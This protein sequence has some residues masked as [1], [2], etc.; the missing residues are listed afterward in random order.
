MSAHKSLP[1]GD[2]VELAV[3]RY[4]RPL[5][6]FEMIRLEICQSTESQENVDN[7][8]SFPE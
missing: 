1:L 6:L 5:S 3:Q 2:F 4:N 7:S 8:S